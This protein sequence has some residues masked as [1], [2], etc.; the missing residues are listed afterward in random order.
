MG[1]MSFEAR[2]GVNR[3]SQAPFGCECVCALEPVGA[4]TSLLGLSLVSVLLLG[5][6]VQG[7]ALAC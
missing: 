3:R 2:K 5:I 1:M 6:A 7:W 4:P